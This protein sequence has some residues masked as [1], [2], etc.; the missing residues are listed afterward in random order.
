MDLSVLS[1]TNQDGAGAQ[2]VC[3]HCASRPSWIIVTTIL[4]EKNNDSTSVW[5]PLTTLAACF[6]LAG[7]G[8]VTT[9]LGSI[10]PCVVGLDIVRMRWDTMK[11][12]DSVSGAISESSEGET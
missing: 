9:W 5:I 3:T 4:S 2:C 6:V 1:A 7:K 10:A 11:K 12:T 8:A